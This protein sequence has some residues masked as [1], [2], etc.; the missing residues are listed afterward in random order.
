MS[1][2]LKLKR[3]QLVTKRIQYQQSSKRAA[4]HN[5]MLCYAFRT[6]LHRKLSTI[7]GTTNV[8]MNRQILHKKINA[9]IRNIWKMLL[10]NCLNT[11]KN[12]TSRTNH[13][14]SIQLKTVREHKNIAGLD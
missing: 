2:G 4:L 7:D 10:M 13:S 12:F 8:T 11:K 3:K 1:G 6:V 5:I 14:M 9:Q